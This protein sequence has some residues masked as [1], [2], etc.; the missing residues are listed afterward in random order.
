MSFT[1]SN[2]SNEVITIQCRNAYNEL[3][4]IERTT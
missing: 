4:I 2:A 3:L 1:N